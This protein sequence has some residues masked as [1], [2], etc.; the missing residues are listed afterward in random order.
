MFVVPWFFCLLS[1][2]KTHPLFAFMIFKWK[3]CVM[4]RSSL[5]IR[6]FSSV[7]LKIVVNLTISFLFIRADILSRNKL[8]SFE[9]SIYPLYSILFLIIN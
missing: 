5:K 2:P 9:Y 7:V 1:N 8:K 3:K 6:D 4:E